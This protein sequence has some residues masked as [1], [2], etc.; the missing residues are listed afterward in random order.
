MSGFDIGEYMRKA[1]ANQSRLSIAE[2]QGIRAALGNI[3]G[4]TNR[5]FGNVAIQADYDELAN[6]LYMLSP[7]NLQR[8]FYESSVDATADS[9]AAGKFFI[10]GKDRNYSKRKRR[11]APL[12][13]KRLKK[14]PTSGKSIY[15]QVADHLNYD[16][17]KK[18]GT[19]VA[20][21]GNSRADPLIG[22]HPGERMQQLAPLVTSKQYDHPT[23]PADFSIA[24]SV[25]YRPSKAW[26]A[27]EDKGHFGAILEGGA[28]AKGS[29]APFIVDRV[30]P[31]NFLG[32][33]RDTVVMTLHK[34]M[35]ERIQTITPG[36]DGW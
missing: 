31:V 36:M 15:R 6:I 1:K 5:K 25:G 32:V 14:R 13:A 22:S 21:A 27:G 18:R 11:D 12:V 33:M 35:T 17:D 26:S 8:L 24:N 7:S 16:I 19:L 34:V 28:I 23:M 2:R 4:G 9:V 29:T 3:K 30:K 20:F 10:R